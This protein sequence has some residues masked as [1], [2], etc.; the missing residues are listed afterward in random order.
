MHGGVVDWL[1]ISFY[2]PTFNPAD[3]WLR[4]GL[5]LAGCAWLW[6]R[7]TG[8]VRGGHSAAREHPGTG[9]SSS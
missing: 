6:H 8:H 5:L 1:H 2:G 7:R 4:C 3:I 9:Q